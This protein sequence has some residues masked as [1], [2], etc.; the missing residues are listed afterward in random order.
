M[1]VDGDDDAL[2]AL[3]PDVNSPFR[4]SCQGLPSLL[5]DFKEP[6]IVCPDLFSLF[7][8]PRVLDH[9]ILTQRMSNLDR[10]QLRAVIY[11]PGPGRGTACKAVERFYGWI[12]A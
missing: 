4:A 8:Q 12:K 10:T 3:G 6:R 2:A 5:P 11:P 7:I 9:A 1:A